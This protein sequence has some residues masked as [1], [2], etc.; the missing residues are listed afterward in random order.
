MKQPAIRLEILNVI[1]KP[2]KH[3]TQAI[4]IA[5][6]INKKTLLIETKEFPPKV[7]ELTFDLN[8]LL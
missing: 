6:Y 4:I 8:Y 5:L 3:F 2:K 1:P 7:R